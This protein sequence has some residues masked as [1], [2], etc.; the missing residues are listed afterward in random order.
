EFGPLTLAPPTIGSISFEADEQPAM[1]LT[2]GYVRAR[3]KREA[4]HP[5]HQSWERPVHREPAFGRTAKAP[6]A[7]CAGTSAGR[8][9]PLLVARSF[10]RID[11]L[12]GV[13]GISLLTGCQ[14]AFLC[15]FHRGRGVGIGKRRVGGR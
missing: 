5:Y 10:W 8:S 13:A 12:A 11:D 2:G 9:V 6:A 3:I 14:R 1:V 4:D 7:P 15:A